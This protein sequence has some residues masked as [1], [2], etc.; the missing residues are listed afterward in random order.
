M[1]P[2]TICHPEALADWRANDERPITFSGEPNNVPNN[3]TLP[4]KQKKLDGILALRLKEAIERE[5]RRC[6][7]ARKKR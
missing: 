4:K 7:E 6:R 5:N 1:K 2:K 3:N